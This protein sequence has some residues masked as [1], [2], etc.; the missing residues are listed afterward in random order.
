MVEDIAALG[1]I[2]GVWAHPDDETFM[3]GGLMSMAV[4]HGQR[5]ICVTATDGAGG[6]QDESRWPAAQ[7]GEIR[8]NELAAALDVLGVTEHK[9][10]DYEDGS[11]APADQDQAVRQLTELIDKHQ[12]D[13]IITFPPDGLTGHPDH[14]AVSVWATQAAAASHT[15]P[16]VYFATQTQELYDAFWQPIHEKFTV[17]FAAKAPV[18]VPQAECTVLLQ[19]DAETM[20][21]KAAAL[22]AMPSQYEAWFE[23]LGDKGVEAAFSTEALVPAAKWAYPLD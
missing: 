18:L 11:C 17:Y 8:R 9:V 6:V 16:T 2:M 21:R 14:R 22:K 15:N 5:V 23:F 12:P 13:T 3:T 10:L 1:T 7:L 19:L 4:Q 20:A